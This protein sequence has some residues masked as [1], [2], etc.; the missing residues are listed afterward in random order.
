M[1]QKSKNEVLKTRSESKVISSCI[2]SKQPAA[3][4]HKLESAT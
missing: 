2:L 1:K 3:N 4:L